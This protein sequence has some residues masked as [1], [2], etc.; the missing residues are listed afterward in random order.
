MSLNDDNRQDRNSA[1]KSL[2][3]VLSSLQNILEHKRFPFSNEQDKSSPTLEPVTEPFSDQLGELE[4]DPLS[5]DADNIPVLQPEETASD[6]IDIPVLNDI[7]F[8]GLEDDP[9]QSGEIE[10][11]LKQLRSELDAIVGDIM[12]EARQQFE[13]GEPAL[14]TENSMQRFLRELS[15]KTP[16]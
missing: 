9:S 14:A 6:D 11:Q 7:I 15:Q 1:P 12:D 3:Q 13:S 10:S 16:D 5:L 8:K 2:G 4:D